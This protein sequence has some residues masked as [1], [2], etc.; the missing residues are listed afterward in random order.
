MVMVV[1]NNHD[2]DGDGNADGDVE[3]VDDNHDGDGDDDVTSYW[4]QGPLWSSIP[5]TLSLWQLLELHNLLF[6]FSFPGSSVNYKI[7]YSFF[8][9]TR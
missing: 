6:S 8:L 2:D 1:V 5:L 4:C 3:D 9:A 7:S